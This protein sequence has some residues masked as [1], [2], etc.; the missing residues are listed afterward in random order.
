MK[1]HSLSFFQAYIYRLYK[2][3]LRSKWPSNIKFRL[4]L[5]VIAGSDGK[6]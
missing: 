5:K 6:V 3:G 4:L 2:D 1:R